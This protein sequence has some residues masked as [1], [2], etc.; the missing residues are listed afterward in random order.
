MYAARV[1]M[2]FRAVMRFEARCKVSSASGFGIG[3]RELEQ[4][5]FWVVRVEDFGMSVEE[6][7]FSASRVGIA[8]RMAYRAAGFVNDKL[9]SRP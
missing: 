8:A 7:G 2:G 6:L 9:Y 5:H 3:A 4:A 1:S